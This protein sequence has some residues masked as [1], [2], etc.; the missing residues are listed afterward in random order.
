LEVRRIFIVNPHSGRGRGLRSGKEIEEILK[1]GEIEGD[2]VYTK[3][4]GDETNLARQAIL[5][6]HTCL[7]SVGGEGTGNGIINGMAE[8]GIPIRIPL[9]F[10]PAGTANDFAR[11]LRIP[12]DTKGALEVI[13]QGRE[14]AIDL[15]K[16]WGKIN[17]RIFLN[18]VSF[19]FTTRLLQLFEDFKRRFPLLPTQ[20]LYLATAVNKLLS[21]I[22]YFEAEIKTQSIYL[23]DKVTLILVANGPNCGGIFKLAPEA[24]PTDGLLDVCLIKEMAVK[25]I[26]ANFLRAMKGTHLGLPE[27]WTLSDGKLPQVSSLTISSPQNLPCEMDG[28][29]LVA[30]K[31]YKITL[32]PKALKVIVP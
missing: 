20:G 12:K 31:E 15:G 13:N 11:F 10:V 17:E 28:E 18:E 32:L 24:I 2:V 22:E 29:L 7:I 5:D 1:R 14:M 30:E 19:G 26:L 9:G 4:P 8:L 25:K 21:Q 16:V 3:G 6:G 27:V 23:K